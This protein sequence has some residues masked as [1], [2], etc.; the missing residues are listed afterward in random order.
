METGRVCCQSEIGEGGKSMKTI[1][2]ICEWGIIV[3][4]FI[5]LVIPE[6][7]YSLVLRARDKV[8]DMVMEL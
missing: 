7:L 8:I 3:L 5:L 1:E 4:A 6:I 2:T